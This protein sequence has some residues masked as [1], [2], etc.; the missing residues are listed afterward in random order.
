MKWI[1]NLL[2]VVGFIS[3]LLAVFVVCW[4]NGLF[5]SSSPGDLGPQPVEN[6]TRTHIAH[7]TLTEG[8]EI[9]F[10]NENYDGFFGDGGGTIVVKLAQPLDYLNEAWHP[11]SEYPEEFEDFAPIGDGDHARNI[12]ESPD[13]LRC[14]IQL[15]RSGQHLSNLVVAFYDPKIRIVIERIFHT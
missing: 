4:W 7:H 5:S 8:D 15:K 9:V 13:A 14:V 12:F 1:R 11:I 6:P 3:I 2:A 10:Q